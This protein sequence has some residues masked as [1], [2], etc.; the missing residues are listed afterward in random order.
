V[1]ESLAL[2]KA[3]VPVAGFFFGDSKT[4]FSDEDQKEVLEFV[5]NAKQAFSEGAAVAYDSWW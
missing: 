1:L 4:P 5:R 3:L 2:S